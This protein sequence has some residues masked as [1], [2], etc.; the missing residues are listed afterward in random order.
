MHYQQ[1]ILRINLRLFGEKT[2]SPFKGD[3]TEK[4]KQNIFYVIPFVGTL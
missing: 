4:Q 1:K 3:L 2:L